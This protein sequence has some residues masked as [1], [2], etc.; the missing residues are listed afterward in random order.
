MAVGLTWVCSCNNQRAM[1]E[2]A[3]FASSS[4]TVFADW[5]VWISTAILI[6]QMVKNNNSG[7]Q[8]MLARGELVRGCSCDSWVPSGIY[9]VQPLRL[10]SSLPKVSLLLSNPLSLRRLSSK[11]YIKTTR[12]WPKSLWN[13]I[14]GWPVMGINGINIKIDALILAARRCR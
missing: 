5:K 3:L 10:C 4:G 8:Y 14:F 1:P 13:S 11:P 6:H 2:V 12:Q 7:S 9:F